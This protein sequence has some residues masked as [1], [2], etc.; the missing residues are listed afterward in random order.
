M[1]F[2]VLEFSVSESGLYSFLET[3]AGWDNFTVLYQ[4]S[5]DPGAPLTN[6]MI[7][8]D[9]YLG[10]NGDSGF[11]HVLESGIHYFFVSTAFSENSSGAFALTITGPGEIYLGDPAAD[12]PEPATFALS[13]AGAGLLVWLRRKR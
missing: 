13:A 11:D 3:T 4:N 5:F 8:N 2:H 1:R 10:S 9:D 12:V 6:F 7:G